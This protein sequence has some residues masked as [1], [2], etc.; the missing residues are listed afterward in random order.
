MVYFFFF[1][2]KAAYEMRISDWSS[3]VCSSDLQLLQGKLAVEEFRISG[4]L[5]EI[6]LRLDHLTLGFRRPAG[7]VH[8]LGQHLRRASAI[9]IADEHSFGVS[10]AVEMVQ[11]GRAGQPGEARIIV[12]LAI[13]FGADI[14]AGRIGA[15][16]L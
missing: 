13:G 2:E 3:D 4:R 8:A 5:P 6:A 9:G 16:D 7:P 12:T 15:V 10:G 14:G 11:G 1:K